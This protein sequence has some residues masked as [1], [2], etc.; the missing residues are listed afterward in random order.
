MLSPVPPFHVPTHPLA[1][2]GLIPALI[3]FVGTIVGVS[4][5]V[6]ELVF[7]NYADEGAVLRTPLFGVSF[8]ATGLT[9]FPALVGVIVGHMGVRRIT[10]NAG[11]YR[12]ENKIIMILVT[13]YCGLFLAL[14]L[15][16]AEFLIGGIRS[17]FG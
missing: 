9:V 17:F 15:M 4:T 1:N 11:R 8:L 16:G 5:V 3:S 13:C 2:L 10:Q 12:G 14:P 7:A 6:Y